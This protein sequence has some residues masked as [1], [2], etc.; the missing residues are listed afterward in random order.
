[1]DNLPEGVP[2][3]CFQSA[4]LYTSSTG[5]RKIRVQTLALPISDNMA[6]VFDNVD[7]QAI[8]AVLAKMGMLRLES[9]IHQP[10]AI[11]VLYL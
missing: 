8:V 4:L 3:V 9:L 5:Q 6:D 10:V 1:M 7:A 2:L 11:V